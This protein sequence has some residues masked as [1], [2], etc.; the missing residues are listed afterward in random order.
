MACSWLPLPSFVSLHLSPFVIFIL[1]CSWLPPA[2][3]ICL[4]SCVSNFGLL[5]AACIPQIAG[6]HKG[7]YFSKI[8]LL[9]PTIAKWSWCRCRLVSLHLPPCMISILACSWLSLPP[10]LPLFVSLHSLSF[11]SQLLRECYLGSMPVSLLVP[12]YKFPNT[13][14]T[15]PEDKLLNTPFAGFRI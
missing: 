5:L 15:N 11:V 3:F 1:A 6:S 2:A 10:C 9:I 7:F 12:V 4:P 14:A 8:A 13:T